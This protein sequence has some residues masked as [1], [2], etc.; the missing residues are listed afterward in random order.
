ME[1]FFNTEGPCK[2]EDHYMLPAE[3]RIGGDVERLID[4]KRYFVIHA[5]RQVGKTTAFRALAQRLTAEGRY[6]ALLTTCEV[7]QS[8]R[9]DLDGSIDAVLAA[10]RLR[11]E[12]DLPEEFR[13]PAADPGQAAGARLWDLLQRWAVASPRPLVV[14]FDEIDSLEGDALISISAPAARGLHRPPR[15]FP[16]VDRP[17]RPTRRA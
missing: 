17:D 8:I 6:N 11:A 14:F 15:R 1:R 10:I 2:A 12:R 7:G 5:P 4:R 3:S 16:S 9:E 13:P